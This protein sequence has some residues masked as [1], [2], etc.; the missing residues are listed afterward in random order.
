[1]CARRLAR[2]DRFLDERYVASGRLPFAL[3]QVARHGELVHQTVLGKASLETGAAIADD[4]IVR[5]YSMTKPITS[6]AFMMLVEE[7]KVAL[8]DPCTAG[9]RRGASSR[10]TTRAWPAASSRGRPTRRCA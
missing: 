1:M 2:I 3:L 6:V 9:S 7:G 8:D 10:S 5:I 4:T